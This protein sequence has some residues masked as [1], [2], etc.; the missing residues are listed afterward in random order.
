MACSS[1]KPALRAAH[2]PAD[3]GAGKVWTTNTWWTEPTPIVTDVKSQTQSLFDAGALRC[4]STRSSRQSAGLSL[5]M[6]LADVPRTIPGRPGRRIRR[7]TAQR[8]TPIPS[9]TRCRQTSRTPKFSDQTRRFSP[10]RTASRRARDGACAGSARRAASAWQVGGAIGRSPRIGSTLKVDERDHGLNRSS[11]SHSA[12][13]A[14]AFADSRWLAAARGSPG[15]AR[16]SD[17]ARPWRAQ[18]GHRDHPPTAGGTV[19]TSPRRTHPLGDRADRSRRR[20]ALGL[21]FAHDTDGAIAPLR[22]HGVVGFRVFIHPILP[23][24]GASRN[25]GSVRRRLRPRV[26]TGSAGREQ[27]GPPPAPLLEPGSVDPAGSDD[28]IG[29]A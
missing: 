26:R 4:R 8:A 13:D 11:G 18:R 5:I 3:D 19:A 16:S 10:Q 1:T 24:D 20:A 23:G 9:R 12:K 15:P 17:C 22:R 2:A 29:R 25:P 28:P 14:L 6:V 7:A 21:V 27:R